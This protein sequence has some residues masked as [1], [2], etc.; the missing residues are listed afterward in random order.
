MKRIFTSC[1]GLGLLPIAPGTWGSLPAAAAFGLLAISN[2]SPSA[3]TIAMALLAL[4]SSVACVIFAPYAIERTGRKDPG[5]VVADELAGQSLVFMFL[6]MLAGKELWLAVVAGFLLFRFFD[7][8]KP[9]PIRKLEKLPAGWGILL[10]DLLAGV[11]AAVVLQIC[12]KTALLSYLSEFVRFDGV[13]LNAFS[14]GALGAIQGLTEFLPVSSDGHLILL[15]KIFGFNTETPQMLL[16]GLSVHIGTLV[17]IFIVFRKSIAALI[18]NFLKATKTCCN[19]VELY[20]KNLAFKMF[21]LAAVTVFVTGVL[22]LAFKSYFESVRSS[23]LMLAA[24]WAVNGVLLLITDMR[25]QTRMGLRQFTVTA[26][27][28]IGVAQA[29]AILPSISRSGATICAAILLGLHRRWAVEFSFLVAIPTILAATAVEFLGNLDL[30]RSA[31]LPLSAVIIGTCVAAIVGV[32]ALKI[33]IKAARKSH[34]KIFA[35]YCFALAAAL[36]VYLLAK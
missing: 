27:I 11:F 30:I 36:M 25:K 35:F 19:P 22:G 33:L 13:S 17:S 1:F 28:I 21:F 29:A 20:K 8:F 24:M 15:E 5:E 34:L 6:P 26:A 14:A 9:W 18:V 32:L 31:A 3:I 23:M 4:A 16:F 10:D 7:I 12:V 2:L